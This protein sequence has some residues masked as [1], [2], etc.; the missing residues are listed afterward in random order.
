MEYGGAFFASFYTVVRVGEGLDI[1]GIPAIITKGFHSEISTG[2]YRERSSYFVVQPGLIY[3][4]G[5]GNY[6]DIGYDVATY[7]G[8]ETGSETCPYGI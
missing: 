1:H 3:L 5:I 2:Y 6:I 7:Q 8:F 4:Q